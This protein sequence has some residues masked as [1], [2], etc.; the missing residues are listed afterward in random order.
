MKRLVVLLTLA[1][2]SLSVASRANI[3]IDT[4]AI[5]DKGNAADATGYG[6]VDYNYSIGK[7]EVTAGQY[8]AF[9]N[10]AAATDAYALY[11]TN[12]WDS[13]DGCMIQRSGDSGSYTYSVASDYANRPVNYVSFWDACRFANWLANGQDDGDTETGA[14]T[15]TAD[16]TAN[17]TITRNAGCRWAVTSEN[18]WYKAA[19]YRGT[20]SNTGYWLF[21]TSSNTAPGR[22]TTDASGNN[23]NY[24]I[25]SGP[26]PIDS[27]K[28]TTVVGQF[29]YSESPYGTFDQGGNVLEWT[30][31][32][33][34]QDGNYLH[35][36]TRGGYFASD[37]SSL[38]STLRFNGDGNPTNEYAFLGFRVSQIPEPASITAL[39]A[40][41]LGLL[42]IARGR[43]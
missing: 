24:W 31:A 13:M 30:D 42:R 25:G 43:R 15:L 37:Y 8:A 36:I 1:V 41:L 40:G 39:L 12:M 5:G 10:A 9:L 27:T 23:A 3:I 22:D 33:S 11:S 28:Y 20:G 6:S 29:R 34:Y 35:R 18:E 14:Y 32:I 19:Y 16:G 21:P 26:Y 38:Q 4:V 7:Y 17:N 2:L